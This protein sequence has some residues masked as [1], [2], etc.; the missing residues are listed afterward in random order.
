MNVVDS[1]P[2][3]DEAVQP[4]E[5]LGLADLDGVCPEPAQHREVLAEVAL[6]G[7]NTNLHA[8]NGSQRDR[9]RRGVA[10]TILSRV[11]GI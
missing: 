5:L 9:L 6:H 4:V 7:E 2:G 3:N 8:G 11:P 1:P 10:S